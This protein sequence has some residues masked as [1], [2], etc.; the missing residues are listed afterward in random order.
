MPA[1]NSGAVGKDV[2]KSDWFT[3]QYETL[4]MMKPKKGFHHVGRQ[5]KNPEVELAYWVIM[6]VVVVVGYFLARGSGG[7]GRGVGGGRSWRA[8]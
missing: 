1:H 4:A 6:F 2:I 5:F 7:P 8:R 3:M